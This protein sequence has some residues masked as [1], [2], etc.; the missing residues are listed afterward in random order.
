MIP[1]RH[2]LL[3]TLAVYTILTLVF[4]GLAVYRFK[5]VL[6]SESITAAAPGDGQ[7]SIG[8]LFFL[9]KNIEEEG[10]SQ[11]LLGQVKTDWHSLGLTKANMYPIFWKNTHYLLLQVFNPAQVYDVIGFISWVLIGI[12][13]FWMCN[14]I[15]NNITLS[16]IGS[17]LIMH[18]ENFPL[19]LQGHLMGL[20]SYF[21]PIFCIGLAV[22]AGKNFSTKNVVVLAVALAI[23]FN[24]N[25]YLGYYGLFFCSVIFIGYLF[26]YSS[27]LIKK[28]WWKFAKILATGC[29][30]GLTSMFLLY[31]H[32][33]GSF[34]FGGSSS[35]SKSLA[36]S[37]FSPQDFQF[38][39]LKNPLAIFNSRHSP[40]FNYSPFKET[41]PENSFHLGFIVL[42]ALLVLTLSI[43]I[44]RKFND[45]TNQK[46]SKMEIL[47]WG[48][49]CVIM[50]LFSLDPRNN[51]SLVPFTAMIAPF[52]RVSVRAY[53]YVDIAI[54]VIFLLLVNQLIE[55]LAVILKGKLHIKIFSY[56]ILGL[57]VLLV[58]SDIS[59]I[60]WNG[61]FN[62]F[63]YPESKLLTSISKEPTSYLLEL[64][65]HHPDTHTTDS[66]YPTK[67]RISVHHQ[68]LINPIFGNPP[69]DQ[70]LR[71]LADSLKKIDSEVL[72]KLADYGVNYIVITQN[73]EDIV[74]NNPNYFFVG[75]EKGIKLYE[76]KKKLT[77]NKQGLTAL[78]LGK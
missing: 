32:F 27:N 74:K 4:T 33:L 54:V 46:T 56:A 26:Q 6:F 10:L 36:I 63:E 42:C 53:L 48:C 58:I 28:S 64:P 57:A 31:H 7:A 45:R 21:V 2:N 52:F 51:I 19:R 77:P 14:L 69:V 55:H 44:I 66:M 24:H 49:S 20:A 65:I 11:L 76:A 30:A 47:I 39:S 43:V 22:K 62:S 67:E 59:S 73:I 34:F 1:E 12:S 41:N 16:S 9:E 71:A 5:P 35:A 8:D 23:N 3:K 15:L 18:L 72:S 38:Y 60:P 68:R 29:I 17:Y 61:Q 25:E 70:S 40:I 50:V 13:S 75:E 78:L 37:T